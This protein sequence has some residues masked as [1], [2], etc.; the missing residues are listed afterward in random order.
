MMEAS[1]TALK[2]N[3]AREQSIAI[4]I[5]PGRYCARFYSIF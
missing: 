4:S 1:I 5:Y 3:I 2:E